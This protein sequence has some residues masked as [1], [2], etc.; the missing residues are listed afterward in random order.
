MLIL[1]LH[2]MG[3]LPNMLDNCCIQIDKIA[4][5]FH[6]ENQSVILLNNE[7]IITHI[8][9]RIS[10]SSTD[11]TISTVISSASPRTSSASASSSGA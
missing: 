7:S 3:A 10:S 11:S 4:T 8:D 1:L 2:R 9:E 5:A 6:G